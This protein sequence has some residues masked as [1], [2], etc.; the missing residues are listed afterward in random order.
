MAAALA[1]GARNLGL[2]WPNPSVG[3]RIVK[4]ARVVGEGRTAR[5]GRPHAE[6]LALRAA[7]DAARGATVYVTLEPCANWGRTP[8][9][10]EGLIAAG[11]ARVVVACGDPDPRVDGKGLAW[12]RSAGIEVVGGVMAARAEAAHL[13]LYRRILAGRPMVSLKLAQSLDGRIAARTGHSQWVT[14]ARARLEAHRLRATHDAILIGSNTAIVDDPMLTCRLPGVT[15]RNPVRVV[16][17]RRLRLPVDGALARS[18]ADV[19]VWVLTGANHDPA[20][21]ER[22]EAVGVEVVVMEWED[23]DGALRLLARRGIT[24]L[25]VEGGSTIAGALVKA[26]LVDRLHVALAPMLIGGDGL[27]AVAGFGLD[28]VTGAPRFAMIDDRRLGP[29]RLLVFERTGHEG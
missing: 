26:D 12:L 23:V 8:P 28:E 15:D 17:D 4:D 18:A 22:L 10:C 29:D 27:P 19:P 1:L 2:T 24:R 5:G 25:M 16:L 6:A 3:C 14:G 21:R 13:G 9:C 20:R 11:V 7:G